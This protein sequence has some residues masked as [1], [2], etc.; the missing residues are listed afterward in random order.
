[1][2]VRYATGIAV[3]QLGSVARV[4]V[5]GPWGVIGF[6]LLGVAELAVPVWAE[7]SGRTTP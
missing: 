2:R 5:P 7:F 4:V 1:V 6:A 3:V